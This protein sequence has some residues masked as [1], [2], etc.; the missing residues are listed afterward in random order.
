M[1]YN[2]T[3]KN[4]QTRQFDNMNR[5]N[6]IFIITNTFQMNNQRNGTSGIFVYFTYTFKLLFVNIYYEIKINTQ[7]PLRDLQ[8]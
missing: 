8:K 6:L 2:I 7:E 3:L 5:N 1:L 4:I